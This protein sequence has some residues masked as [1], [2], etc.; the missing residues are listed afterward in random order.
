MK[1]VWFLNLTGRRGLGWSQAQVS[2]VCDSAGSPATSEN[3]VAV[4]V[5]H[6]FSCLNSPGPGFLQGTFSASLI[7][8]TPIT[9]VLRRDGSAFWLA[10]DDSCLEHLRSYPSFTKI[11]LL[12]HLFDRG[13]SP[14]EGGERPAAGSSLNFGFSAVKKLCLCLA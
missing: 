7:D 10:R 1:W 13:H 12:S 11:H 5:W 4:F 3:Q 6:K 8:L 14:G 2:A 9:Y